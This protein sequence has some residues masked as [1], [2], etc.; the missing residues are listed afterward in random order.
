MELDGGGWWGKEAGAREASTEHGSVELAVPVELRSLPLHR[1]SIRHRT[2]RSGVP[3]Y[4]MVAR[5]GV[6]G[7]VCGGSGVRQQTGSTVG[8]GATVGS[9]VVVAW[10]GLGRARRR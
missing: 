7:G 3:K 6:W 10:A 4:T 9:E 5:V 2:Y 8:L 1:Y